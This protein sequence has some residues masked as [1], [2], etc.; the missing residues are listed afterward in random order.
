MFGPASKYNVSPYGPPA[1]DWAEAGQDDQASRIDMREI[2]DD[3]EYGSLQHVQDGLSRVEAAELA[4]ELACN[5]SRESWTVIA[6]HLSYEVKRILAD[7]LKWNSALKSFHYQEEAT[8]RS[9]VGSTDLIGFA[10]ADVLKRNGPLEHI[11]MMF[12]N[13]SPLV[14]MADALKHNRVLRYF[15]AE[16]CIPS[17]CSIDDIREL[18]LA[19][20]DALE[21]NVTL[22]SF[23]LRRLYSPPQANVLWQMAGALAYGLKHNSAL[24]SFE[25]HLEE[26]SR[27]MPDERREHDMAGVALADAL[28]HHG[29][30]KS[31]T[32]RGGAGAGTVAAMADALKHNRMIESF[33][34]DFGK[35]TI[36]GDPDDRDDG[37]FHVDGVALADALKHNGSL[38]SFIL[39]C[40][41]CAG[42]VAAM[43]DALNHNRMMESFELDFG[44][45]TILGDGRF[46]VDGVA[47]ADALKHNGSLKSFILRGGAGAGTVAAMADALK[48]NRMVESFAI[49][50]VSDS[51]IGSVVDMAEALKCSF[52]LKAFSF[53]LGTSVDPDSEAAGMAFADALKHNGTLESMTVYFADWRYYMPQQLIPAFEDSLAE[54]V[55]IQAFAFRDERNEIEMGDVPIRKYVER[56]QELRK[57]RHALTDLARVGVRHSFR[58]LAGGAFRAK[59]LSYFL[60]PGC[61]WMPVD[62][63]GPK[64]NGVSVVNA[65]SVPCAAAA[66][67]P[68]A[69]SEEASREPPRGPPPQRFAEDA[70]TGAETDDLPDTKQEDNDDLLKAIQMSKSEVM[71][72]SADGA[73]L[74]K[75]TRRARTP[76][77]I[78][79]LLTSPALEECRNR[80][81]A[82]GCLLT[83]FGDSGAKCFVPCTNQQ[84][85][86]LAQAGIELMDYHI[87]ALKSDMVLIERALQSLPRSRRPR[88]STAERGADRAGGNHHDSTEQH[89]EAQG[90]AADSEDDGASS[91]IVLEHTFAT[92]SSLGFQDWAPHEA[93]PEL[94]WVDGDPEMWTLV[95]LQLRVY[96]VSNRGATA[97]MSAANWRR[98][99]AE[100]ALQGLRP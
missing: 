70:R 62:F 48:H 4:L 43:A 46:D 2:V 25:L 84:F 97:L 82:A 71:P 49:Q 45:C 94:R 89:E 26:L 63:V 19:M 100:L 20:V 13:I 98:R 36:P 27:S 61:K 47:L 76:E 30:L 75:L 88:L 5:K 50:H 69:A 21:H 7:A 58:S 14:A 11:E 3:M 8:S 39:R 53:G 60:P 40:A 55:S 83:P 34:L 87:L 41:A 31:F 68:A 74:L 37:R 18:A 95:Q 92:D 77:V 93:M 16:M 79:L 99:R 38:K 42:T 15:G 65:P 6:W 32:L 67:A 29:S 12:L 24:E 52:T 96:R 28:K 66:S 57:Q 1:A 23:S 80:V 56:N 44:D 86:D 17:P 72:L 9:H 59:V 91:M 90:A 64:S 81:T 73:V 51:Q 78:H 10:L 85:T 33:E 22:K 35:C 54:D